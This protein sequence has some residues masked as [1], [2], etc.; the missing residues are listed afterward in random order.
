[1]IGQKLAELDMETLDDP[2]FQDRFSK[3]EKEYGRRAWG[4]MM[5]LSNIPNYLVGFISS[6]GIIVLLNPLIAHK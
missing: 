3:V 5:P 2:V 4:L 1:M 6:V